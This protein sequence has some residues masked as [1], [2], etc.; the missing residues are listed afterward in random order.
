MSGGQLL[1]LMLAFVVGTGGTFWLMNRILN[2]RL[3]GRL[4][5]IR[6]E[7][8]DEEHPLISRIE[9]WA[10]EVLGKLVRYS[11][12]E[13]KWQ[14]SPL[15]VRFLNAGY[16]GDLIVLVYFGGKTLLALVLPAVYLLL[17][18]VLGSQ[19]S[20]TTIG[21]IAVALAAVGYYLPN[22]ILRLKIRHRQRELFESFPDALDLIRVCVSAGLG[23]DAA[24]A[25]VGQELRLKSQVLAEE[26]RLLS[27]E[28]RAG[29]TR[30]QALR[31]LA[32]RT[33]VDDINALVAMLIQAERF[34]TNV[35]DSLRVHAEALRSKRQF[36]AQ[37]AAGKIPVKLTI[38]MA[39]CILPA[40][41]I[42]IVGPA[43]LSILRTLGGH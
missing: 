28:L 13:E 36:R 5:A 16:R 42:V 37:E 31:N 12:D 43:A 27:L 15:R 22:A 6:S 25:R 8:L 26:F 33:G 34:G 4:D 30:A 38:P 39:L 14:S 35:S 32:M 3:E 24:I 9:V 19:S 41:F 11:M 20:G 2:S 1:I 10:R 23:L 40:L 17:A 18:L 7:M 29:A 21:F